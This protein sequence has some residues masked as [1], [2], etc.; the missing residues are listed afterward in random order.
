MTIVI[1]YLILSSIAFGLVTA[2]YLG[3]KIIKLI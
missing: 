1:T 3:F 2:L